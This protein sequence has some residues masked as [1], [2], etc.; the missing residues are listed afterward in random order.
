MAGISHILNPVVLQ[1]LARN[2]LKEDS[3]NFDLQ[4]IVAGN[5]KVS[6]KIYCK[7]SGVL[8]GV[9]FVNAIFREL[10]CS[11]TWLYAEGE[12]L[13]VSKG[14]IGRWNKLYDVKR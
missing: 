13:D 3:P 10:E 8:A 6:A 9:P 14:K 1:E 2:W 5:Q 7:S 11:A 4:A 12:Y